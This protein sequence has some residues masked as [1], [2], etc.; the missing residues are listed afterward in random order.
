MNII[1]KIL[2]FDPSPLFGKAI[3]EFIFEKNSIEIEI[4]NSFDDIYSYGLNGIQSLLITD[5]SINTKL[6]LKECKRLKKKYPLLQILGTDNVVNPEIARKCFYHKIDGYIGKTA[7]INQYKNA[8][9]ALDN[10]ERYIQKEL[11]ESLF[12]SFTGKKLK[13]KAKHSPTN[14]E[15]EILQLIIDEF[16][17]MEIANKLFISKCTVETHR[18][19]LLQKF[20]V[21]N[22]AGLVREA[23]FMLGNGILQTV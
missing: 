7:S 12:A 5:V 22:T 13:P 1:T 2:I 21:K 9:N 6:V 18:L 3:A 16:T 11:R 14:R 15:L 8:L 23:M 10:G 17:T 20:N 19:N 4:L